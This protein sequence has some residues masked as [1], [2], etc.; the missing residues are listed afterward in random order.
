[1]KQTQQLQ[2]AKQQL[3]KFQGESVIQAYKKR[4]GVDWL[5]AI[6]ELKMLGIELDPIYIKKL[7][8]RIEGQIKT[9]QRRKLKKQKECELLNDRYH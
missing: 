8:Q 6:K 9:N 5:C 2:S 7:Q 4:Y 1:M 3:N